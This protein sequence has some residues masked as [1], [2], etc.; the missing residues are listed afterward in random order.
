MSA[1]I[2]SAKADLQLAD[3]ASRSRSQA[4]ESLDV[5]WK[6]LL[7][8]L[9]R[10]ITI[11]FCIS[12]IQFPSHPSSPSLQS[13]ICSQICITNKRRGDDKS[14]KVFLP[15]APP[16]Q[17]MLVYVLY[18]LS[19]QRSTKYTGVKYKPRWRTPQGTDTF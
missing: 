19:L 2:V 9:G 6:T 4:I 13:R 16:P 15:T 3:E 7:N 17:V 14:P 12:L 10:I 11:T 1:A 8:H 5:N 18:N